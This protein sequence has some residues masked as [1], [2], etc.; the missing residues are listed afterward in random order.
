MSREP[1]LLK[2]A[3]VKREYLILKQPHDGEQS[4]N[5]SGPF[6]LAARNPLHAA[7]LVR[8]HWPAYLCNHVRV[9]THALEVRLHGENA[10]ATPAFVSDRRGQIIPSAAHYS[11][12]TGKFL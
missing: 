2:G 3:N 6:V 7:R 5:L 11:R 12:L 4:W 1:E 10:M 8:H 9:E